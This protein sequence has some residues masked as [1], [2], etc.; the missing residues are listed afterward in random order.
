MK[1]LSPLDSAWLYADSRAT[2]MHVACLL[3]LSPPK[4]AKRSFISDLVSQLKEQRNM[5]APWNLRLHRSPLSSILPAWEVARNVDLDYHVRHSALPKPG[6]ERELGVLVSRLHSQPLDMRRPLW[7][8]HLIEGLEGGRI[9]IY[10]KMHHSLLDGVA[11]MKVMQQAMSEDP[12]Q[13]HFEAPWSTAKLESTGLSTKRTV[14]KTASLAKAH[15]DHDHETGDEGDAHSSGGA[16]IFGALRAQAAMVPDISR[17]LKQVWSGVS[18]A[19]DTLSSPFSA[20]RSVLNERINAQRRFATQ[21]YSLA[22][23]QAIATRT[24]VSLNDVVLEICSASL[25]RFLRE[26]G[27]LPTESLTAGLPVSFRPQGDTKLGTAISFII[28]NLGTDLADPIARLKHIHNSTIAAKAHLNSL[29][30]PALDGYTT[31]FMAPYL[32]GLLSGIAGHSRPMFSLAISNVPGPKKP[33]YFAGAKLEAIYPVSVLAHGQALN[34]T[35]VSY[36]GELNFG[37]TGCRDILP[38]MQR[39]AVYTGDALDELDEATA[40]L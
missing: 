40:A 33:L 20:P 4:N 36:A 19:G 35:C 23:L 22:R 27:A 5:V 37:F 26:S 9:A 11:A 28:A 13:K 3:I 17:A 8:A 39:L 29:P 25:R 18:K 30:R 32:L 14:S 7:E 38:H 15:A 24:H 31:L 10:T 16:D 21:T 34:I 12:N 1:I 6:G 2:P